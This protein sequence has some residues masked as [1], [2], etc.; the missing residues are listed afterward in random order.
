[1]KRCNC[2]HLELVRNSE[3]RVIN[4]RC[5]DC[6]KDWRWNALF[7]YWSDSFVGTFVKYDSKDKKE[8]MN[9]K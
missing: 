1:M 6:K 8:V 9:G 4:I 3:G 2:P 7:G 5:I